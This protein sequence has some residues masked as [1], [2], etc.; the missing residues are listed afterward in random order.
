MIFLTRPPRDLGLNKHAEDGK[1]SDLSSTL[2]ALSHG[3]WI[4]NLRFEISH[5]AVFQTLNLAPLK[6]VAM[7]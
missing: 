1:R 7:L 4:G 2:G 3:L 6:Q 5:Q